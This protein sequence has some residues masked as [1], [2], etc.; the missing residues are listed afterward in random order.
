M[1]SW[2][3][4]KRT[5]RDYAL[6]WGGAML[7]VTLFVVIFNFA[8]NSFPREQTE[9]WLSIPW[10]RRLIASLAGADVLELSKPEGLLSIAFNHP[11][12]WTL[13]VAFTLS[14]SSGVIAGEIDRGTIDLLMTL[15]VSRTAVYCSTSLALVMMVL[16]LCWGVW[17][18]AKLGVTLT[19][20]T[21]A[22]M[23]LLAM[24]TCNLCAAVMAVSGLAMAASGICNRRGPAVTWVF[25]IVFYGFVVN[26]LR[27][28]WPALEPL[29]FTSFL[30]YYAPLV[31]IRDEAFAW[32]SMMI[33]LGSGLG[34]W[35][36]GL[37]IFR[38]RD[39]PAC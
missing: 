18:G 31:I 26:F 27:T 28:M 33:L 7:L 8:L 13:L 24:V 3:I 16:P 19:G 11:L 38:R 23:S 25:V 36:V 21:A 39:I 4:V 9:N 29:A 10:I 5:L 12:V 32:R 35:L 30:S 22:R 14:L 37:A 2:P 1:I 6:L 34:F 20:F 15:P 17:L